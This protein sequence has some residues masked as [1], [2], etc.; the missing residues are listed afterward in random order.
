M[1]DAALTAMGFGGRAGFQYNYDL[2]L[3]VEY[4]PRG[5]RVELTLSPRPGI[6]CAPGAARPAHDSPQNPGLATG[7]P[8]VMQGQSVAGP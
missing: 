1:E 3:M 6:A 7:L 2:C 5:R 8:T 4:G